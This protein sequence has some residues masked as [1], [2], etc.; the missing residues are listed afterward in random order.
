M[1][2]S[3]STPEFPRGYH[4]KAELAV[5]LGLELQ[6]SGKYCTNRPSALIHFNQGQAEIAR[7]FRAYLGLRAMP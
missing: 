4:S 1:V 2:S 7:T 3:L 5:V 6:L